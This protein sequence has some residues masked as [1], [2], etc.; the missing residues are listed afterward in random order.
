[1][2]IAYDTP[3]RPLPR[4]RRKIPESLIYEIMDGKPIYRKGYRDVLSGKKTREEIRGASTLQSVIVSYLVILIGKFIDD[5]AYFVLTGEPGVHLDH[6]NNLANDI[7]IYDQTVLTPDKI[8]KKYATVPPQIAIEVDIE[9]DT[10]EMTEN[11]YIYKKTRKLFEFGVQKIIWVL[12][13][14]Q[15]VLIATPDRTETVNWDRDIEIMDG[16]VFNIGAYLT[17]KGITIE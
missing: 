14:P 5:D 7:A 13:D 4:P 15:V 11:G 9:A 10:A 12:T 16:H 1:M 3:R 8:S 17:K 2:A 6:R